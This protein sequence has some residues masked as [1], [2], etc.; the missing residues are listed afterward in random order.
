MEHAT[1]EEFLAGKVKTAEKVGIEVAPALLHAST[2]PHQ[3]DTILWGLE[4]GRGGLFLECGL[5]KSHCQIEMARMLHYHFGGKYILVTDL[6]VT[7]EFCDPEIGE[8]ARLGVSIPY[9]L[10]QAGADATDTFLVATNYERVRMG[11]FDFSKFTGAFLDEG[12]YI[13]DMS[14][15]TTAALQVEMAKVRFKYISTATPDPNET[16]ELINYAHILGVMDRGQALTRFF[17]R[18][19]Q[20]AGDLTL[21]PQHADDF[22]LWVHSWS[23]WLSSPSDLGYPDEGYAL[24]ELKVHYHEVA[25]E[26]A[27]GKV[28]KER[29]GQYKALPDA[30]FSLQDAAAV[31]KASIPERLKKAIDI[32]EETPNEHFILWH[33]LEDER[34][35]LN[36]TYEPMNKIA[37][38]IYGDIYGSQS[39]ELREKRVVD[40]S[41]GKLQ[42]LA[43]KPEISGVGCNFQKFCHNAIFLGI[44]DK[45]EIFYQAIRRILR[46]GQQFE[47]NIHIIFTDQERIR[48]QR[49]LKKWAKHNEEREKMRSMIKR[50]GLNQSRYLEDK[51]RSFMTARKEWKGSSFT[52]VNSDSVH[53]IKHLPDNSMDMLL[54]SI[55]FGN[56][57][58][59]THLYNDFGHNQTDEAFFEQMSFLIPEMLR[60]LKPGRIAAIHTKDRIH[61]G[62]V[63]GRGFS[64]LERFTDKT[65]D[66]FERAGFYCIGYHYV[67]TDVVRENNQT[68]R[69]GWSE[70]CKDSTKMGAGIP[71]K[72]WLF[73]KQPTSTAD[74]YADQPVTHDKAVFSRGRWQIDAHSYWRSSGNRALTPAELKSWGHGKLM[75]W[76]KEKNRN[77]I[78]DYEDHVAM[79]E[80]LA[81]INKLPASFML[82]PPQSISANVW[83]DINFMRCLNAEQSRRKLQNHVCPMPWDEIDR[84][85]ELYSNPGDTI[86]DFFGGIGSTGVRAI[87][88]GRRAY[89]VELNEVY[90]KC[91]LMYLQEGEKGAQM[92]SLF[93]LLD[94][95]VA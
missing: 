2:K 66:A 19:S 4:L 65:A 48:L 18:N 68:Y 45:F 74:A 53:E 12:S 83:D 70:M 36:A 64:T 86:A 89:I 15:E 8:G 88:K 16:L 57:Y 28:S 27:A 81:E 75:A 11:N 10:D 46:Y 22:W 13:K 30:A 77:E 40:F 38:G 25:T 42:R 34:R 7:Q 69:L 94:E 31:K 72:I 39:W 62:S 54:T 55:P 59:Y 6:G 60:V 20:K 79:H 52:L 58:E 26:S 35:A 90:A 92:P 93:D 50:Y 32:V 87:A 17:Q 85:I 29:D 47:V 3:R 41:T 51:K 24:P 95:E 91:G 61:Y 67:N 84:L 23:I 78:Y 1:Y 21:H 5:G 56:H 76:W 9:V 37:P 44:D 49:L 73:R 82:M 63:T 14:S 71:E 80:A 43:T 33:H